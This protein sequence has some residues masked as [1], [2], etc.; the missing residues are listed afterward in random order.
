[1]LDAQVTA[2]GVLRG[3]EDAQRWSLATIADFARATMSADADRRELVELIERAR[4]LRGEPA[5]T[6]VAR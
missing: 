5:A 4:G 2:R 3:A 6:V 1:M